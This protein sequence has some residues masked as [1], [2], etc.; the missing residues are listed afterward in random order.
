LTADYKIV[1]GKIIIDGIECTLINKE[2]YNA[3]GEII[4]SLN[5]Y[6]DYDYISSTPLSEAQKYILAEAVI[7]TIET[8][9]SKI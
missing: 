9:I 1:K 8:A 7:D 2:T 5:D 4:M 6:L 3:D